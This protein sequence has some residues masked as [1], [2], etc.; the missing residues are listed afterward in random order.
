MSSKLPDR[1]PIG[2]FP[3]P[4]HELPWL[5]T[6]VGRRVIAK[7]DDLSG[8]ALG[9]NKARKLAYL[10]ADARDRGCATLVATGFLQSN[11]C[12]Q[13]AAAAVRYGL[14]AV[15]VS[16]A[17]SPTQRAATCS[18]ASSMALPCISPTASRSHD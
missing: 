9:G 2:Q 17:P 8:L 15:S 1:L 3:T 18:W 13:A 7:R 14:D 10:V 16:M 5:S 12:V 4:V 6:Q 11:N